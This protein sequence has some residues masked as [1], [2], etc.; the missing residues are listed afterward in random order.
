MGNEALNGY[1]DSCKR[2]YEAASANYRKTRNLKV[3]AA[4]KK[5]TKTLRAR[6]GR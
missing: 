6:N 5:L 2:A 3:E 4:M 1:W